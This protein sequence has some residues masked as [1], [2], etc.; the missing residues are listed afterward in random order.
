LL[1]ANIVKVQSVGGKEEKY[2]VVRRC[3]APF[4]LPVLLPR[5]WFACE[6]RSRSCCT[7][8][9]GL[10]ITSRC[11]SERTR[12]TK[13]KIYD[14]RRRRRTNLKPGDQGVRIGTQQSSLLLW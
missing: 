13:L 1:Q 12:H 14:S 10:P 9:Y 5:R 7:R 11:P 4:S 3:K 6:R 2:G 8:Y